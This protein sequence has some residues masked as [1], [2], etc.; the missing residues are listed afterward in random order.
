M[1]ALEA[2][3][4]APFDGDSLPMRARGRNDVIWPGSSATP[5]ASCTSMWTVGGA[6]RATRYWCSVY[7]FARTREGPDL[8]EGW[9]IQTRY[10]KDADPALAR[11]AVGR[12]ARF[13]R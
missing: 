6:T 13:H 7:T 10:L 2:R 11:V 12:S 4:A 9:G 3:S 1:L 8:Q 5:V